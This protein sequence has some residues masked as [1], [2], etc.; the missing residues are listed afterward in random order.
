LW[1]RCVFQLLRSF[2]PKKIF[3]CVNSANNIACINN[4]PAGDYC[5]SC[6]ELQQPYCASDGSEGGR[7]RKFRRESAHFVSA[8]QFGPNFYY[9]FRTSHYF[10]HSPFRVRRSRL[11]AALH[12]TEFARCKK[13]AP[14]FQRS[15]FVS[16]RRMRYSTTTKSG[17]PWQITRSVYTK[18]S[19]STATQQLSTNAK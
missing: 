2:V 9:L 14:H 8:R 12:S 18:P 19:T 5:H 1:R 17:S 6:T 10:G 7:T 13:S 4:T 3:W 11:A 16:R 15:A